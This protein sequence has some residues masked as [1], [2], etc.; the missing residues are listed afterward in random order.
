MYTMCILLYEYHPYRAPLFHLPE[1]P[2]LPLIMVGPGTGI[3]PFRSF[4]QQRKIDKEML[5]TPK[6][7][8]TLLH[9]LCTVFVRLTNS[10]EEHCKLW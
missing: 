10:L 9:K 2:T 3:A 5:P 8:Y 4:W 6:R 7:M 1:D